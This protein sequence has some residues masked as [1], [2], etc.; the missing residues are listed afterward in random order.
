[1]G[2]LMAIDYGS[3]RVGLAVSDTQ[4]IIATS[5]TTVETKKIFEF[6]DDYLK[7]EEVDEFIV[8]L[9]KQMD[10]TLSES[11][12]YIE[13]FV[14][15]LGKKYPDKKIVRIDERFTSK[16]ASRAILDSGAKKKQRRDKA[17]VDTVSAVIILQSYMN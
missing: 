14:L 3:K 6:L 12:V 10:N 15:E 1:M 9:A 4:R 11:S 5:L 2:R 16:I 7:K 13:P 8:G 17:L